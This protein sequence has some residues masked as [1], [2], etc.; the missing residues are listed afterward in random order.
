LV[1]RYR[2]LFGKGSYSPKVYQREVSARVAMAARR[3]GIGKAQMTEHRAIEPRESSTTTPEQ[4][5][6]PEQLTLL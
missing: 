5:T 2:S 1:D 3:H 4:P 6:A